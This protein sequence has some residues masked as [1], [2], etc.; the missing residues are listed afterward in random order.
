MAKVFISYSSKQ[1]REASQ[2]C[3]YL[4]RHGVLCW[5]APRNIDPGSN[6]ASQIVQAIR[7]SSALVLLASNHT[8]V[9]GHVSNEVFLEE[10]K[11]I[12]AGKVTFSVLDSSI[13]D[14]FLSWIE[15][16]RG[17]SK[18]TRNQRL[19]ALSSFAKFALRRDVVSAGA[20]SSCVLGTERKR[21][22]KRSGDD[23]VFFLPEEMQILLSLPNRQTICGR[24][25]VVLMSFLYASGARAQE[26]CDLTANDV[27]F[28]VETRVR[29]VGK[30]S[31]ARR[32]V[33]PNEC[34]DLLRVHFKQAG[35]FYGDKNRH[36]FSSQRNEHMT[37]SCVEEVVSKYVNMAKK[38][39][40][41]LF[42]QKAYTPHAFR[43]TIAVDM[44]ACGCSL[45]AIKAFLGHSSIQ[46][47]MIYATVTSDQANKILRERGLPAKLPAPEKEKGDEKTD[48]IWFLRE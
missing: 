6:Y 24:R 28:G 10:E 33:I 47:T 7:D 15:T 18:Q 20:F 22:S 46:S 43:H 14:E 44:L 29:L 27:T 16:T 23:V 3:E 48:V 11:G 13:V 21:A 17:C 45:P 35:L 12:P 4:E 19:A 39:H 36:V 5:M 26:L 38:L 34:A 37:I 41:G 32:I 9:S 40:P 25:D 31:K 2:V 1:F 8:N 42:Q 30:G